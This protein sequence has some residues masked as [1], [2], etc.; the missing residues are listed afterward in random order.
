MLFC[1][2]DGAYKIEISCPSS[3]GSRFPLSLSGC[4]LK[5]SLNQT[6]SSFLPSFFLSF[7]LLSF[8]MCVNKELLYLTTYSTHFVCSYITDTF[9][10]IYFLILLLLLLLLL[11]FF[12]YFF[13]D[14]LN[15]LLAATKLRSRFR[16]KSLLHR[17]NRL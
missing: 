7:L 5:A 6:Y 1:L 15:S 14:A 9:S 2:W 11:F 3:G 16:L 17:Q 8:I 13:F 12:F 10:N 4:V